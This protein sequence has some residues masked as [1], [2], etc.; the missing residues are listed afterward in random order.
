MSVAPKMTS[1]NSHAYTMAKQHHNSSH[2]IP[3][4]KSVEYCGFPEADEQVREI[5]T[6]IHWNL[7]N[8]EKTHDGQPTI[9]CHQVAQLDKDDGEW[10]DT[11][12]LH[13]DFEYI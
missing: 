3:H 12:S 8:N 1:D 7:T 10:V 5:T 2:S 11:D 9:Q 13:D 4:P 6:I